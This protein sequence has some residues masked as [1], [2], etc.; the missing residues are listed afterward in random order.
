[1]I[2]N[3]LTFPN[4]LALIVASTILPASSSAYQLENGFATGVPFL[5][6]PV[7]SRTLSKANSVKS[8]STK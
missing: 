7:S 8:L 1:M 5:A 6:P 4:G 3:Q 2:T